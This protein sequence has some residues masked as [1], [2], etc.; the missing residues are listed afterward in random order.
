MATASGRWARILVVVGAVATP[1]LLAGCVTLPRSPHDIDPHAGDW[2]RL[3]TW[4]SESNATQNWTFSETYTRGPPTTLVCADAAREAGV[5]HF[6]EHDE[7][8]DGKRHFDYRSDHIITRDGACSAWRGHMEGFTTVAVAD[9]YEG[10]KSCDTDAWARHIAV[11]QVRSRRCTSAV[12][13]SGPAP[14]W[15]NDTVVE[16]RTVTGFQR[17]NTP[18]GSFDAWLVDYQVTG[19]PSDHVREAWADVGCWGAVEVRDWGTNS[20]RMLEAYHCAAT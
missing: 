9:D 2:S 1:L 4:T 19:K 11:G 16:T 14:H 17:V 20:G 8:P 18:A 7:A 10:R 12:Q 6:L 3:R 15:Q 13:H 5:I